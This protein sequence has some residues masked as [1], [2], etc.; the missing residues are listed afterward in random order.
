MKC[1]CQWL[2]VKRSM[3]VVA[4]SSGVLATFNLSFHDALP[5]EIQTAWQV[6]SLSI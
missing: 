6:T 5:M 4:Y 1:Q 2:A 3:A